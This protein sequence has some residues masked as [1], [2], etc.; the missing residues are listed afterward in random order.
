MEKFSLKI[1]AKSF[2]DEVDPRRRQEMSD[3]RM[4]SEDSRGFANLSPNFIHQTFNQDRFKHD[5]NSAGSPRWK[6]SEIGYNNEMA[7]R[8]VDDNEGQT[9]F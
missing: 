3:S 5:S 2:Y 8:E 4:I 9:Q 7:M 1:M 6:F